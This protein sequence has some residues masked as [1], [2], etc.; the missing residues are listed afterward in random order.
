[1]NE[2]PQQQQGQ[3]PWHEVVAQLITQQNAIRQS[4]G[5]VVQVSHDTVV[6]RQAERPGAN[7]GIKPPQYNGSSDGNTW[8]TFRTQFTTYASIRWGDAPTEEQ[9]VE[10][11]K[12]CFLSIG[13]SAARLLTGLGP[14]SAAFQG[15]ATLE[16]YL[17]LLNDTF[18]PTSEVNLARQRFRQRKQDPKES[19]QMYANS[20]E[21][22]FSHAYQDEYARGDVGILVAEFI[23][24]L[25]NRS[26]FE[27]V[28]NNTPYAT[29]QDCVNTALKSVATQRTSVRQGRRKN[30]GGLVTSLFEVDADHL[31]FGGAAA[32][33]GVATKTDVP[34]PMEIGQLG[35]VGE[36]ACGGAYGG[37]GEAWYDDDEE[38]EDGYRSIDDEAIAILEDPEEAVA[39]LCEHLGALS[40]N[41]FSGNCY[42]CGI[43]GHSARYCP[44]NQRP[45]GRGQR[46]RGRFRRSR[47]GRGTYGSRGRGGTG[48]GRGTS[49]PPRNSTTGRFIAGSANNSYRP[50]IGQLEAVEEDVSKDEA[51]NHEE[52]HADGLN[53]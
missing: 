27:F 49:L 37:G 47:G 9:I 53:M 15:A 51:G 29:M 32:A 38:D 13:K 48:F 31:R 45:R 10:Q 3:P 5:N 39:M 21:E 24:G 1:M 7:V 23:D 8:S 30:E 43:L 36:G 46:G 25:F 6:R 14:T 4:L 28:N 50:A 18:R 17:A 11:K 41:G 42:R 22:L 26:V 40:A 2:Q 35:Y 34:V 19:V 52:G 12:I 44:Q 16:D 20:K 33:A